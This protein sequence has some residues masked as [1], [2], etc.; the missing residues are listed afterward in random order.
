ME[1][2]KTPQLNRRVAEI[3]LAGNEFG[4][5]MVAPP[6]TPSETVRVLREAYVRVLRDG[7]LLAE[8]Q[9]S[10]IYM[11]PSSGIELEDMVRQVMDQPPEVIARLKTLLTD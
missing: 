9:R 3:I 5:P 1:Q 10:K 7:D 4:R 11:D 8:V 2:H 6:G